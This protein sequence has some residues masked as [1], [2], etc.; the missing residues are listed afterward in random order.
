MENTAVAESSSNLEIKPKMKFAGKVIKT[1]LA[2]AV[3]EIAEG[4][5]AVLH[6]SQISTFTDQPIKSVKDVLQV[7][8]IIDVWVRRIKDNRIELTM[9]KPLDLEWREI[10]PD[11]V[12]KGK[13]V[14]IENFGVFLD[15]GAERPGLIH[16]SELAHG[17]VRTPSDVVKEGDELEAK[18]IDV[19]KKKKQIKLSVKAL[20]PE[21]V[22]EE[23]AEPVKEPRKESGKERPR[24]GKK[25]TSR[26]ERHHEFGDLSAEIQQ[27]GEESSSESEPT[28]MEIA[29]REAMER[30]K[31]RK[32][33]EKAKKEKAKSLSNEQE[34]IL[35]RTLEHKSTT[36]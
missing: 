16:I 30:A 11:M 23:V 6:I 9:I 22:Q 10:K 2:G 8:Q 26:Q 3:V 36:Q 20:L 25:N 27:A 32:K 31:D 18:V 17:Y 4:Q 12:V 13:V 19:N 24:R 1:T 7:G 5:K 29:L 33:A 34:E 14:R 28:A 35:A 21:P 15:I